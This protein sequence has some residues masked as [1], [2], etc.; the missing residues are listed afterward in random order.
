M[1]ANPPRSTQFQPENAAASNRLIQMALA[2]AAEEDGSEYEEEE[3]VSAPT[4]GVGDDATAKSDAGAPA[5]DDGAGAAEE[6]KVD[7][8]ADGDGTTDGLKLKSEGSE[9]VGSEES[10]VGED[11]KKEGATAGDD[12]KKEVSAA[13][14]GAGEGADPD[15]NM[16]TAGGA[17]AAGAASDG[18]GGGAVAAMG[19]DADGAAATLAAI[20]VAKAK[21]KQTKKRGAPDREFHLREANPHI[22]CV[23]CG[24]YFI[25]ATTIIE[26]L[27]TFC[28]SCIVKHFQYTG[29]NCPSCEKTV[30]ET[31]P[32]AM[33]RP[34]RTIQTI[35][36]KIV[37]HLQAEEEA[38]EDAW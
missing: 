30:H 28:K 15:A 37:K 29:S 6:G 25:D 5:T 20:E 34:D 8:A 4:V 35:V 10:G 3:E 13:A 9:A 14:G 11:V 12:G 2:M 16:D 1:S 26:C 17:A 19:E 27:H 7:G 36:F 21:A 18:A 24:G 32:F 31:D 22:V 23:L 38:R 33:L